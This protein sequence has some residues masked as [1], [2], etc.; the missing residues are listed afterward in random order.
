M[1]PLRVGGSIKPPRKVRDVRPN[2][3]ADAL[4]ARVQGVVILQATID[5]SGNVVSARVLRGQPM[6]DQAAV[7]A[8]TQWQF[9]PTFFNGVPVPLIMTVTVNFTMDK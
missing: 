5:Q 3:P 2:Y 6:L 8:A 4:A 7:D 9:E 1:E